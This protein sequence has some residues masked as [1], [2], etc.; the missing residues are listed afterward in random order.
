[1]KSAFPLCTISQNFH[2]YHNHTFKWQTN[3]PSRYIFYRNW[4]NRIK[5][6]ISASLNFSGSTDICALQ[7]AQQMENRSTYRLNMWNNGSNV[8]DNELISYAFLCTYST[9]QHISESRQSWVQS[10]CLNIVASSFDSTTLWWQLYVTFVLI[11]CIK[12]CVCQWYQS[13]YQFYHSHPFVIWHFRS[14]P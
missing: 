6:L 10:F 14:L 3:E 5:L 7:L 11:L 1:M 8:L 2:C 12:L 13:T 9:I 4:D